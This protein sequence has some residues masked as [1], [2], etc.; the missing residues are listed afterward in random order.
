MIKQ[1]PPPFYFAMMRN[2]KPAG[3][4]ILLWWNRY[5]GQTL[6]IFAFYNLS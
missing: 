5:H 4:R 2:K 1:L 6:F 3:D